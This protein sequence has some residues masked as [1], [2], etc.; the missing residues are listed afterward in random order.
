MIEGIT[1]FLAAKGLEEIEPVVAHKSLWFQLDFGCPI[2][3][4]CNVT[5][6]C[7]AHG[8]SNLHFMSVLKSQLRLCSYRNTNSQCF[9][10]KVFDN[11]SAREMHEMGQI[12]F[13]T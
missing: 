5:P 2:F 6:M 7:A 4:T 11:T 12:T 8:A 13:L 9:K 3:L 10:S 1:S